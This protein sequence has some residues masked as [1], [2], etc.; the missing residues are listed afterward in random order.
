MGST[1]VAAARATL[2]RRDAR[3]AAARVGS[4]AWPERSRSSR[5][6]PPA[7]A[8]APGPRR[9]RCPRLRE[10]GFHVR[11]L[12][13]RDADEALELAQRQRRRRRREPRGGR[14]RRHGA[15]RR[16]GAGRH[17]RPASGIIPAGTG[18]DV[19]RYLDMPAHRPAGGR[20]RGGRLADPAH[21]PGPRAARTYFVTVLAAGFD[22]K[23]NERAN[24]MALAA[25]AR[26]ATTW[27]PWPSCGSSSRC[28][29][30]SSSTARCGRSRRCW[31][32]SATVR[33]SAAGCGSPTAPRSTTAGST[34]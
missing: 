2:E 23:V 7:R 22:A 11:S 1:L 33:R 28:P 8:G 30:P 19:A 17:A 34:W 5:T 14:R 26:C 13:G 24:A 15:P 20:R 6:R 4:P 31:S 32:R 18:N 16:A 27:P 12:V 29:T 21:R 3:R 10:A 25:R 9:S